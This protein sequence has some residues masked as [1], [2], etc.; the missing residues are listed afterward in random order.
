[1]LTPVGFR[2]HSHLSILLRAVN[3]IALSKGFEQIFCICE[4]KHEMLKSIKGFTR[5][6]TKV[7]LYAK[8]IKEDAF[9]DDAHIYIDG[10]DM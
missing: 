7:Y 10:I 3:N 8:I 1:M 4:R 6:D 2:E 9:L 5:I